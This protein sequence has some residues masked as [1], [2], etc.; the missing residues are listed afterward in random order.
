[1]SSKKR[2]AD[3]SPSEEA[4]YEAAASSKTTHISPEDPPPA[5]AKPRRGRKQGSKVELAGLLAGGAGGLFQTQARKETKWNLDN[6]C[7]KV[8]D[9]DNDDSSFSSSESSATSDYDEE[10]F[11]VV[12]DEEECCLTD[13]VGNRIIPVGKLAKVLRRDTCC[14]KCAVKNHKAYIAEFLAFCKAH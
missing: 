5:S 9:D 11:G 2:S 3:A 8:V 12:E 1:M 4:T 14:R 13:I 6:L 7:G 10:D